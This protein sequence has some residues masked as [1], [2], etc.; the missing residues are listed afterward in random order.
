MGYVDG[1][2]LPPLPEGAAAI[3]AAWQTF[4]TASGSNISTSYKTTGIKMAN[5]DPVTG[6]TVLSEVVHHYYPTP[7][8]GVTGTNTPAPQLSL[9]A[10][11]TTAVERGLG[12]KGRMYLPGVAIGVDSSTGKVTGAS[13]TSLVGTLKTFFDTINGSTVATGDVINASQGSK[14]PLIGDPINRKVTGVKIGDVYDTQRR[15]RN[16]LVEVYSSQALAA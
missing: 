14:P 5:L 8:G 13:R 2:M 16:E 6:K 15:R 7:I 11:L 12:N 1:D 9:V 10:T 4:F 3:A